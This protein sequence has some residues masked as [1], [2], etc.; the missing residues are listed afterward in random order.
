[1]G[2]NHYFQMINL[3]FAIYDKNGTVLYG[4]ADNITLW[5]GFDG[6]WSST[7]DGDPIVLYDQY[8]DRWIATQ[9]SFP[10]YPSGPFYELIAVSET[11][12]PTGAWYRYAYQF[13]NLP[14]YPKF[15]IWP[16]G[17]YMSINQFAPPVFSFAGAGVCIFDRE[18]MIDG[19]PTAEMIFFSLSSSASLLPSDADGTSEPPANSPNYFINL[20]PNSL[21]VWEVEADWQNTSN[22]SVSLVNTLTTQ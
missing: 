12:D 9:F 20:G 16:D 11:G 19:D 21:R 18:K 6:P 22:S 3:S 17:Y 2:P 10:N 14:D 15:G 5:D 13:D 1:M 4:P 7:N 8:E